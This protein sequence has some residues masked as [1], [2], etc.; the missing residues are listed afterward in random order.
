VDLHPALVEG[1]RFDQ[2]QAQIDT[3]E[4][5]DEDV[6]WAMSLEAERED[7]TIRDEDVPGSAVGTSSSV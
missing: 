7:G 4:E 2:V 1:V 3:L 6:L 5:Y